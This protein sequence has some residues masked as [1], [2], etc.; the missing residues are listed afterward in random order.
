MFVR[1]LFPVLS[2]VCDLEVILENITNYS[3]FLNL[4]CTHTIPMSCPLYFKMNFEPNQYSPS[5]LPH[6][7]QIPSSPALT[8]PGNKV[9]ITTISHLVFRG[10]RPWELAAEGVAG[11]AFMPLW[12]DRKCLYAKPWVF[13]GGWVP[14]IL[15]PL[16]S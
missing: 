10:D 1:N 2:G 13:K 3:H 11:N 8:S 14:F 16:F 15:P 6:K 5:R 12:A 7:P 9:P 4:I